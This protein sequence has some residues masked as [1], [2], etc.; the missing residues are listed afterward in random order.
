MS[1]LGKIIAALFTAV[2]APLL[3]MFF[4]QRM[5]PKAPKA[6]RDDR[7]NQ[8]TAEGNGG[9]PAEALQDAQRNAVRQ[10]LGRVIAPAAQGAHEGAISSKVLADPAPLLRKYDEVDSAK[11]RRKGKRAARPEPLI[12]GRIGLRRAERRRGKTTRNR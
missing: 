12:R 8:V 9:T 11:A 10:I 7:P 1:T 3:V 2:V 5:Q 6:G 4:A